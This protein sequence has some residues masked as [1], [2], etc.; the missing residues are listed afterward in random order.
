MTNAEHD[1]AIAQQKLG[2]RTS[3]G[4]QEARTR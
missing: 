3:R 2:I 1:E 4:S